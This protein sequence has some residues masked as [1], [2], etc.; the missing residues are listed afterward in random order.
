MKESVGG[1]GGSMDEEGRSVVSTIFAS[2]TQSHDAF[3]R[4]LTSSSVVTVLMLGQQNESNVLLSCI[5]SIGFGYL[6]YFR[7]MLNLCSGYCQIP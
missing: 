5:P 3:K 7:V 4:C 6:L 1:E 2:L